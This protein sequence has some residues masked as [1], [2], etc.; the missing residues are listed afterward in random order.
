MKKSE[1]E[2]IHL[3][4]K[5]METEISVDRIYENNM[6]RS[7]THNTYELYYLMEGSRDLLIQNNFYKM[8][9]GDMLLIAPGIL[10]KTLD[11]SPSE[12]KRIVINFPKRHLESIM[13]GEKLYASLIKQEAILI[14]NTETTKSATAVLS[15]FENAACKEEASGALEC[16]I[17]S[18]IYK[19]IYFLTSEKNI[20]PKTEI[21]EKNNKQI[22]AVLEYINKNYTHAITLTELSSRFY[23]SEFHLCRNFKRSTGRTVVEYINYLRIKKA[24]HILTEQ[25]TTIKD[26]AKACGFKTTAHFN[27]T[28]KEYEGMN[29]SQF[30]HLRK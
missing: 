4:I 1:K 12:Y 17:A 10:H 9:K 22:C 16:F 7:H 20:L 15:E 19:F 24:K 21:H 3:Y 26:A 28:F 18:M 25:K 14:R 6:S 5:S 8:E 30:L 2:T 13:D 23:V 11:A 29:P 27:H